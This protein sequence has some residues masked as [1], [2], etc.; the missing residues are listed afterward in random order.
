MSIEIP[1]KN[2]VVARSAQSSVRHNISVSV[3]RR[4]EAGNRHLNLFTFTAWEKS[5]IGGIKSLAACFDTAGAFM[6]NGRAGGFLHHVAS[7]RIQ[8][9]WR[10]A[11]S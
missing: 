8:Q 11:N 5:S 6:N 10:Q 3:S 7:K 9:R 1:L 2:V 4:A